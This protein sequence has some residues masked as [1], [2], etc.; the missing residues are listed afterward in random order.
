MSYT[1]KFCAELP[2][3]GPAAQ[4]FVGMSLALSGQLS[5]ASFEKL[6]EDV[7]AN[8]LDDIIELS[9]EEDPK[10]FMSDA[11]DDPEGID[12]LFPSGGRHASAV[13]FDNEDRAMEDYRDNEAFTLLRDGEQLFMSH[14]EGYSFSRNISAILCTT[15]GR[16]APDLV[17]TVRYAADGESVRTDSFGGGA[18]AISKDG[19]RACSSQDAEGFAKLLLAGDEKEQGGQYQDQR[20]LVDTLLGTLTAEE[21]LRLLGTLAHVI[22]DLEPVVSERLEHERDQLAYDHS[23]S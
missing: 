12:I 9:G 23:P 7:Q 21:Q 14:A 6:P 13:L 18:L 1:E 20:A 15:L 4:H 17:I 10:S 5:L 3:I 19:I 16:Y 2:L 22:K 11:K 8:I